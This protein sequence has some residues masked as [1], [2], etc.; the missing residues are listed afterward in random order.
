MKTKIN[1]NISISLLSFAMILSGF[2][3]LSMAFALAPK[4]PSIWHQGASATDWSLPGTSN[5]GV[6]CTL[7]QNGAVLW[8]SPT[9]ETSGNVFVNYP[10]TYGGGK[11]P[12]LIATVTGSDPSIS[13]S[14]VPLFSGAY[15]YWQS[16]NPQNSVQFAW[17]TEGVCP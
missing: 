16:P 14:V 2:A 1:K 5:Y 11:T 9:A 17:M 12:L 4:S 7:T 3:L 6:V 13:Y 10:T 15:I 8:Y